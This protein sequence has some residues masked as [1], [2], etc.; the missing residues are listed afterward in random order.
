[1]GGSPHLAKTRGTWKAPD[2]CKD[3]RDA[4]RR[5]SEWK[6]S[7]ENTESPQWWRKNKWARHGEHASS[8]GRA[9][10]EAPCHCMWQWSGGAT[11][12]RKVRRMREHASLG[13]RRERDVPQVTQSDENY[14]KSRC[15][16]QERGSTHHSTREVALCVGGTQG[17]DE[18]EER[19]Q[20]GNTRRKVRKRARDVG[21]DGLVPSRL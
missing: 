12:D 4:K 1:M 18:S 16:Q 7:S 13:A 3:V 17:D 14:A 6:K 11:G 10:R 15:K 2:S 9:E 5:E 8:G 19:V 20:S 21:Q